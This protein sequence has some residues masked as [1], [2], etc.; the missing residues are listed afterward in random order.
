MKGTLFSADFVKDTSGNLRLLELNTDTGFISASYSNLDFTELINIISNQNIDTID[1]IYKEFHIDF[2]NYFSQSVSNSGLE[3]VEFNTHIEEV[4]AIYPVSIEDSSNKFILRLA[5]D[6]SAIFDST[7]AKNN[8]ELYKLFAENNQTSD[9]VEFAYSSSEFYHDSLVEDTINSTLNLPDIVVKNTLTS[10][11]NPLEFYKIGRSD[12]SSTERLSLVK[13]ELFTSG[14]FT[15]KYYI[16]DESD[17]HSKSIRSFNIVYGGN[18]DVVN[19]GGYEIESILEKPTTISYN[20]SSLL[21]KLDIKHYFELTTNEI[22]GFFGGVLEG[23]SVQP[24]SGSPIP[25]EDVEIGTL[26]KSFVIGTSPNTDV[27][28][29]VRQWSYPGSELPSG[30]QES[31]ST[32]VNKTKEKLVYNVIS[33]ISISGSSED[34]LRISPHLYMLT[35]D[36]VNDQLCYRSPLEMS[37]ETHKL[38]DNSGS[39]MTMDSITYEVLEGDNYLYELDMEE[40]DTFFLQGVGINVKL[41][42]HN[43]FVEGTLVSTPNGKVEIQNIKPGDNVLS[44]DEE[45]NQVIENKVGKVSQALVSNLVKLTFEG[46]EVLQT[47]KKHPFFV[48][49]KGWVEAEKLLN[50]DVCVKQDGAEI[51]VASIE[52]FEGETLV[53]NLHEVTPSHT[54]FTNEILVHNKACFVAGTQITL[55]NGDTKNI[56]DIIVGDVVVSYNEESGFQEHKQVV[57]LESP[58]HDDLVKYTFSN[59]AEITCTYDHP[60][61]V[62]DLTL[63]SYKPEWTNERYDLPSAVSEI[64]VGDFVYPLDGDVNVEIVSIEELPRVATKTYI[65]SVEDNRNFYANEILVHNK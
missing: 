3:I 58:I 38:F 22:R 31:T 9:V 59:G 62:N 12:L 29:E 64:K 25:I 60:F 48:K 63:S 41:L 18:L 35:Y 36:V 52:I 6:E 45:K 20:D 24:A 2:I 33:N 14:S 34:S 55:S 21:N 11:N 57:K 46:G 56:E 47:T 7:Y 65:F 26:F 13:S 39:L 61:Y 17:T 28:S 50:G 37:V 8:V 32:L 4:N 53:Y 43:C 19:I 49:E 42:T 5:Y 23:A 30:S 44:F 51:L 1:I 54:F 10:Y 16:G 15:Q 40:A 27:L